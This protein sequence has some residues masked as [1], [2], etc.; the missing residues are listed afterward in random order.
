MIYLPIDWLVMR[1]EYLKISK[2]GTN[3]IY[4]NDLNAFEES[5]KL[6]KF[7]NIKFS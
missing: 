5:E 4:N 2:T 6:M 1:K 3:S 7:K